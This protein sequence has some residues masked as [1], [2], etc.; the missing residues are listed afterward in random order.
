MKYLFTAPDLTPPTYQTLEDQTYKA[1]SKIEKFVQKD[2][3]ASLRV[4]VG[5]DGD[6]FLVMAELNTFDT[7]ISKKKNR[8]LRFAVDCVAKE[9][10][11]QLLKKKSKMGLKKMTE[12]IQDLRDKLL[13]RNI[14]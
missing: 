7:F 6:E 4:S 11:T 8:D 12:K 5:K 1:F 14:E 9:I 10:K 13:D 3:G 2:S